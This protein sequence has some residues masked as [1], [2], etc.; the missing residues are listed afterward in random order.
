[1][2][3][4]VVRL[5]VAVSLCAVV[6]ASAGPASA[7]P[8]TMNQQAFR[9]QMRN[10]WN[11]H[12]L[13]TRLYIQ[14]AVSGSPQADATLATLMQNQVDIGNA[15]VP[16]YGPDAGATLTA[17][18]QQH[19]ALYGAVL[20]DYVTNNGQFDTD[21]AALYENGAAVGDFLANANPAWSDMGDM[22]K[23]H[24]DLTWQEGKAFADGDHQLGLQTYQEIVNEIMQM[25]DELSAGIIAGFPQQFN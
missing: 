8:A 23:T 21:V 17:L 1:M 20:N 7:A 25:A 12:V 5:M 9:A 11:Q 4:I 2:R 3:M 18:L 10:L 19:I 6:A 16:F 22:M 13:W 24:L 14:K 15:I